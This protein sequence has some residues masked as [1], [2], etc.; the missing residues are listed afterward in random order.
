MLQTFR[1]HCPPET[2]GNVVGGFEDGKVVHAGPDLAS[3]D[4][5][6]ILEEVPAL[7]TPVTVL[8]PESESPAAI[9]SALELVLEG[10]HLSKRLNK[11][12]SGARGDLQGALGQHMA[13]FAYSR[14]DGSQAGFDLDADDVFA[15]IKDDLMYHGDVGHALR[16]M[17]QEGFSDR[18]GRHIEGLQELLERIAD[19]PPP[20]ARAARSRRCLP[21]DSQRA[22]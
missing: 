4:Y 6:H 10:L 5:A 13:L 15:E 9:A 7:R 18:N 19:A 16:R 3:Q 20:R 1:E 11:E 2:L 8:A 21:R 14:W 12:A 22:E 17:L